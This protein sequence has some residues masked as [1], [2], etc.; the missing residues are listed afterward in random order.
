MWADPDRMQQVVSN[1]LS[2]ALK[3][4][5][6]AGKVAV[7]VERHGPDVEITV[8]DTGKGIS[9]EF[10]PHV[11]E[12][13]RQADSSIIRS[14]GGLGLGLAIV[15][16]IVEAHRGRVEAWSPGE[17][18]GATFRVTLPLMVAEEPMAAGGRPAPRLDGVRALVVDDH[19]D[20]L[21]LVAMVLT[22]QGAE[23]LKAPDAAAALAL[24]REKR[25]NV[26]V[27][28]L[29]MPGQSG[30]DLV[31]KVRA[32]PATQGGLT[33]AIALTAYSRSDD[34]VRALMAGFQAHLSKPTRPQE[35]AWAVAGL[36]GQV[37]SA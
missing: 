13:F 19:Q 12:R 3:F 4:T 17:G 31:E 35:L 15:K 27:S 6:R 25:P 8:T 30:Y 26:L 37:R 36:V 11:F 2:N 29:E 32:L 1:L 10:L 14:H 9:P 34:R 33:P 22:Q 16:H 21:E 7:A 24:L 20:G 28:D 23:V 18:R 5:P